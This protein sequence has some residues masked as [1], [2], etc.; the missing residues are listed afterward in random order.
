[1]FFFFLMWSYRILFLVIEEKRR[2]QRLK[3]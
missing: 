3:K 1:M 2:L